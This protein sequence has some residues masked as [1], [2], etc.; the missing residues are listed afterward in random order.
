LTRRPPSRHRHRSRRLDASKPRARKCTAIAATMRGRPRSWLWKAMSFLGRYASLSAS[1]IRI[2]FVSSHSLSSSS[3]FVLELCSARQGY[4]DHTKAHEYCDEPDVLLAKVKLLASLIRQ[5]TQFATYTGAGISTASGI[6]DYA[7][8][9]VYMLFCIS[10]AQNF[11][12]LSPHMRLS[13]LSVTSSATRINPF[14]KALPASNPH[15]IAVPQ[16][17]IAFSLRFTLTATSSTGCNKTT[18]ACRK[19]PVCSFW[20]VFWLNFCLVNFIKRSLSDFFSD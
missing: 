1:I 2:P 3:I 18:M 16:S 12:S 19:R 20:K 14:P 6:D 15:M 8:C 13:P 9:E 10:R 17:H 4:D 11:I 7:R 5:S